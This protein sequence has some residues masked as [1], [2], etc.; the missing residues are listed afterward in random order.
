VVRDQ[1]AD[2]ALGE[3]ADDRLYVNYGNWVDPGKGFVQQ[4]EIGLIGERARP[5]VVENIRRICRDL[6]KVERV[7]EVLTMHM[8]PEYVLATL[9]LE[10]ADALTITELERTI[11]DLNQRIRAAHPEVKKVFIEAESV[12]KPSD[13]PRRSV[14]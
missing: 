2:A 14:K 12:A 11:E 9:S 6:G 10:F 13:A 5:D 3:L 7:N 4:N 8:G 1:H